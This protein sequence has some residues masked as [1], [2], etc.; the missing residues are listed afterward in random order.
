MSDIMPTDSAHD[1]PSDI[2]PTD[3]GSDSG[4]D[5]RNLDRRWI[6]LAMG[7][8]IAIP[9][10]MGVVF[11]EHPSQEVLDVFATVEGLEDGSSVL[12]AY[13]YDPASKGELEPMAAA[14]VRHCAQKKHKLYFITL[15]P[16]A[17]PML[18]KNIAILN[19]EYP[20]YTYGEDYVNLGFRPGSEGVI[21]VV[22]T[23][24]KKLYAND[25]DGTDLN[26]LPLTAN[27]KNIQSMDLIINVS[28]GTPGAKEW[29]QYAATPFD[30]KMVA[31]VTGVG[32]TPL[33]PYV[34]NQLAGILGAIKA[35]AEYEEAVLLEY[36]E[37]RENPATQEGLR[38]M[39]PQLVAH[40]L[41]IGLIIGGNVIF[42]TDRRR[43]V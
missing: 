29:V 1:P 9:M 22:V 42:F 19:R 40:M 20:E 32:Y 24:L 5:F 39:G 30:I 31:G 26:E 27:L 8:S 11:P 7:L 18:Q 10:L 23:D 25:V 2:S 28:A 14:F 35:A 38:K 13:D 17:V 12:M 15:W 16:A 43:G 33:V 34:P 6:F 4:F 3:A 41:V 37:L 36:P 21:K